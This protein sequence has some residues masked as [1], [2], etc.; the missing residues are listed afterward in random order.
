MTYEPIFATENLAYLAILAVS[1]IIT[2][3]FTPITKILAKKTGAVDVPDHERKFHRAPTPRLGGIAIAIGFIVA[4]LCASLLIF[5]EIPKIVLVT[6][7]G[8]LIICAVGVLDDIFNLPAWLKLLAQIAV[9]TLT[10]FWGG[11]I[12]YTTIFGT[13]H[14][15]D[16][17]IPLTVLW[18]VLVINSVNLLDG[19][20]GLACGV[21]FLSAVVLLV[22]SI[23]MGEPVCAVIAAALCGSALGFLPYNANPAAVF[24]GDCGSMLF[25]YVLACLSVFGFFKG[26]TLMSAVAPAL[27]FALPL[28]DSIVVFFKRVSQSKNPFKADRCHLHY[29]L[30]D[31]GF[32]PAQSVITIYISSAICCVAAIVSLY[33]KMAAFIIVGVVCLFLLLLK[34]IDKLAPE[35]IKGK[36][37]E[38]EAKI[39]ASVEI[40]PKSGTAKASDVID[41]ALRESEN[42]E[43]KRKRD[44]SITEEKVKLSDFDEKSEAAEKTEE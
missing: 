39:S 29:K 33:H 32:S 18:M 35:V 27:V 22:I 44:E 8:G 10:A 41:E 34:H 4:A 1:L 43:E 9:A 24:M 36:S 20:D 23:L 5:D 30:L 14:L 42:D 11:A 3:L 17:A 38:N 28:I 6:S 40:K 15:G 19:L 7:V 21:S 37:K 25:G 2:F 31:A 16:F 12:K 13:Q 26:A